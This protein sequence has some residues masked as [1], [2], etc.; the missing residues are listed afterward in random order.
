MR[1]VVKRGQQKNRPPGRGIRRT[2]LCWVSGH[3]QAK[4]VVSHRCRECKTFALFARIGMGTYDIS[5]HLKNEMR[6]ARAKE[7]CVTSIL[8][9]VVDEIMECGVKEGI[10]KPAKK[11]LQ[12][13]AFGSQILIFSM[14]LADLEHRKQGE[15][16]MEEVKRFTYESIVK[17]LN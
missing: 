17:A 16:S 11:E 5:E 10:L 7:C 1:R 4:C 8:E 9:Q 13:M 15:L 14:Y 6:K 12:R 3:A 2:I